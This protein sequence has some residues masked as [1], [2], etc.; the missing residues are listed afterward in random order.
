MH[1]VERRFFR[2]RRLSTGTADGPGAPEQGSAR[3]GAEDDS[4]GGGAQN[5]SAAGGGRAAGAV[6]EAVNTPPSSRRKPGPI[7]TDVRDEKKPAPRVPFPQAPAYGSRLSPG[8]QWMELCAA[9]PRWR[10][11]GGWL[12]TGTRCAARSRR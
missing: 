2:G 10:L 11:P 7:T 9:K 6:V 1:F 8:R 4:A 5:R 12:R 3:E